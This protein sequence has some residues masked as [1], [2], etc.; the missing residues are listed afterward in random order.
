MPGRTSK[1]RTRRFF[2]A[3]WPDEALR[4]QIVRRRQL[5][6]ARGW[7]QVPDHNLHLTLVFLGNLPAE[8]LAK[9]GAAVDCARG[10][11]GEIALDRFGWFPGAQVLWLGGDAGQQLL[12][13]HARVCQALVGA[14]LTLDSRPFRPHVTLYRR[15]SDR[16]DLPQPEPLLWRPRKLVLLQSVSGQ[17]YRVIESWP[18][19]D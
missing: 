1:N 11:A 3:F 7:R 2:L 5:V 9:I 14:G 18:L 10:T 19:R 8:R 12:T 13:L 17:P 16:A 4:V 15:V 6:G